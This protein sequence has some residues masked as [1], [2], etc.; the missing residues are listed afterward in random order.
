MKRGRRCAGRDNLGGVGCVGE[1]GEGLEEGNL[2]TDARVY[3]AVVVQL[4]ELP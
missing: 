1:Y 2:E 4:L 3:R